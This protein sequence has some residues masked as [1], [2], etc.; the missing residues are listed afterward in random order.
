MK[1]DGENMKPAEQRS[2]LARFIRQ[3]SGKLL[4]LICV[5][6][7]SDR[8]TRFHILS[9]KE[10]RVTRTVIDGRETYNETSCS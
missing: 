8:A 5:R 3:S 6:E 10:K 1:E 2:T 7:L 4:C 9:C